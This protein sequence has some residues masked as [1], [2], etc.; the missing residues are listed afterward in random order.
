LRVYQCRKSI[1]LKLNTEDIKLA[2]P[3]TTT[4]TKTAHLT[5][6]CFVDSFP[7]LTGFSIHI[8]GLFGLL[9]LAISFLFKATTAK[10]RQ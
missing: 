8:S 2:N 4:T 7:G 5:S 6:A 3:T 1:G 9:G 10:G